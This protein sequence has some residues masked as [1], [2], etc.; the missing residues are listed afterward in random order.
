MLSYSHTS[1]LHYFF[2]KR[3]ASQTLDILIDALIKPVIQEKD[4]PKIL[5]VPPSRFRRQVLIRKN[6]LVQVR[7]RLCWH[8]L[9]CAFNR[10]TTTR[11]DTVIRFSFFGMSKNQ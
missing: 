11:H 10:N 5:H 4:I 2:Y 3:R 9:I 7:S 6:R 8:T 1:L